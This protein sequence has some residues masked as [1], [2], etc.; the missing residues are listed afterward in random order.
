MTPAPPTAAA[1]A[2]VARRSLSI[3]WFGSPTGSPLSVTVVVDMK[4]P[5]Q[6]VGVRVGEAGVRGTLMR[7]RFLRIN[8]MTRLNSRAAFYLI[9]YGDFQPPR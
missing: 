6:R 5:D 1:A 4:I 2:I 3:A 8:S 7:M 9:R